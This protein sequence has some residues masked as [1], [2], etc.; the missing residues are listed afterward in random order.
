VF[1]WCT[2]TFKWTLNAPS[3]TK[4]GDKVAEECQPWP[5]GTT[6]W[7]PGQPLR[8]A[9]DRAKRSPR[10]Q[11]EPLPVPLS[12]HSALDAPLYIRMENRVFED[13]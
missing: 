12:T 1:F 9:R 11:G 4:T 13:N 2:P 6:N 8:A 5:Y 7:G 3:P 10:G